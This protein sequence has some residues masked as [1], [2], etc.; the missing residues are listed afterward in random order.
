MEI[1]LT[2]KEVNEEAI[3]HTWMIENY[4]SMHIHKED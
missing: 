4:R 3:W 1:D 2:Q